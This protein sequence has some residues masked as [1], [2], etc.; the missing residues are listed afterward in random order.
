MLEKEKLRKQ[1]TSFVDAKGNP[2]DLKS[3][4]EVIREIHGR[5]AELILLLQIRNA[6][7]KK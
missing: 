4:A 6:L 7:L 5:N 2:L 1:Y 3:E